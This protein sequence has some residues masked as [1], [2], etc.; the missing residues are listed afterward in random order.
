MVV[1]A[2]AG[3]LS[4]P[5]KARNFLLW[6]MARCWQMMLAKKFYFTVL[7]I[8]LYFVVFRCLTF[9][10]SFVPFS[11]GT[12]HGW[13]L[14]LDGGETM[15]C[16]HGDGGAGPL[17][18]LRDSGFWGDSLEPPAVYHCAL[19]MLRFRLYFC[20]VYVFIVV[21]VVVVVSVCCCLVVVC[22]G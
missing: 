18:S 19:L 17:W 15:T 6:R 13:L 1:S 3:V 11:V 20:Y 9:V 22:W 14:Q 12:I 8:P 7:L 2:G 4:S 5:R 10:V 16:S 21:V